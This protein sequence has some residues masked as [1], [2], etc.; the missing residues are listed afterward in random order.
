MQDIASLG[1]LLAAA[2]RLKNAQILSRDGLA[3][4]RSMRGTGALIYFDPP[5][6]PGTKGRKN[7]GYRYEPTPEWHEAAAEALR[8]HEGPVVAAGYRSALY[9]QEYEAFGWQRVERSQAANSG[10]RLLLF[11]DNLESLPRMSKRWRCA[12]QPWRPG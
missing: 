1:H 9:A 7:G 3:V 2:Q 12:M 5:Y 6:L 11:F 8:A 10:G 4:I